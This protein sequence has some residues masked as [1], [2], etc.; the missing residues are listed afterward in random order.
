M[1]EAHTENELDPCIPTTPE[2]PEIDF[3]NMK[4]RWQGIEVDLTGNWVR[5]WMMKKGDPW[6][7][8][9]DPRNCRCW[10]LVMRSGDVSN[11][12]L[13]ELDHV[14]Y[15]TCQYVTEHWLMGH[16]EDSPWDSYDRVPASV[17]DGVWTTPF[18]FHDLIEFPGTDEAGWPIPLIDSPFG[19]AM[20][21]HEWIEE[22]PDPKLG[23]LLEGLPQFAEVIEEIRASEI[24]YWGSLDFANG[25]II[26]L[27]NTIR[28]LRRFGLP[29]SKAMAIYAMSKTGQRPGRF[30]QLGCP[31]PEA[32]SRGMHV[33]SFA[34]LPIGG[35]PFSEGVMLHQIDSLSP[36]RTTELYEAAGAATQRHCRWWQSLPQ[37]RMVAADLRKFNGQRTDDLAPLIT[38]FISKKITKTA[39]HN[40]AYELRGARTDTERARIRRALDARIGR[41][42]MRVQRFH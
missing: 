39:L 36:W 1:E 4:V 22:H 20:M 32:P 38:Q 17:A 27:D 29:T 12:P 7:P 42:L 25:N 11:Y 24:R 40:S 8:N 18:R 23:I 31:V 2:T 26:G 9:G 6:C 28:L 10:D 15:L 13:E 33:I 35:Q 19:I 16:L 37:S 30:E 3:N 21:L 41:Q 34:L 5:E 14:S